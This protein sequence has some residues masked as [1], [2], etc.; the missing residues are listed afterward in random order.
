MGRLFVC[1]E[2]V[3]GIKLDI[4]RFVC[5]GGLMLGLLIEI[6]IFFKRKE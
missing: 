1:G 3:G 5:W 2:V 6:G 4:G